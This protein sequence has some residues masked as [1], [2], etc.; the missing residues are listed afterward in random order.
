MAISELAAAHV[1]VRCARHC[2]IC[3]RFDPLHLQV[4]HI[5]L[6]S[7]GGSDEPDNLIAVCLTCH[8]DV[9]TKAPFTRRFT[10]LEL[11]GH[12]DAVY[13]LVA[14]GRLPSQVPGALAAAADAVKQLV[15]VKTEQ[16]ELSQTQIEILVAA[17]TGTGQRQGHVE[18]VLHSLEMGDHKIRFQGRESA[19]YRN[20]FD[21]LCRLGVFDKTTDHR[22][23]Y[24]N[25][26]G[27]RMLDELLAL[28]AQQDSV[29]C[30]PT[31]K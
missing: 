11:K 7:E 26:N 1:L 6:S 10:P 12:R 22:V 9:H 18:I 8:C 5:V 24:L 13:D 20:A 28:G 15:S 29:K 23:F 2:C 30:S 16:V 27:Y 17:G 21:A 31:V 3:R 19:R 14:Q 4:H 25:E